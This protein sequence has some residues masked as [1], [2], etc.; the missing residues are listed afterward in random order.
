MEKL[1]KINYENQLAGEFPRDTEV[2]EI[3][4]KFQEHYMYDIL[5]ARVNNEIVELSDKISKSCD[6]TFYDRSSKLG[7]DVY[8]RSVQFILVLAVK[9]LFGQNTELFIEHSMDKGIYCQLSNAEVNTKIIQKLENE[10]K[11]I[12]SENL[13]FTKVSVSRIDAINYFQ[14]RNQYDK[15]NALKYI[16]NTYI[17]LYKLDNIYDYFYGEM[18]YSTKAINSFALNYIAENGFVLSFPN[19]PNPEVTLPY[20]HHKMIFDKF[21]DYTNWG[22]IIGV[23]NAYDLNSIVTTGHCEELI[24][25]AEAYYNS[26]L[27]LTAHEIYERKENVRLI[28]IAGPSSSGKTTTAKKLEVYLK[29]RGLHPHRISLDDYF[30]NRADTPV[31]ADG[32]LDLESLGAVDVNLFNR[33]LTKLLEGEKV[34]LPEF[35]FIKG[36]R[37]Y[38]D[39]WLQLNKDDV[40]II[41][42]LH[43]LND[44]LTLS[45]ERR[46]KFKIYLS[47]LTQLN[48]DNHNRIHTSDTRKLRR[49]IRDNKHRGYNASQTLKQ[50]SE[51]RR[52]EEKYIFPFQDD[53]DMVINSELIYE[54]AVLKTYVEPLLFSV[55]ETDEMYPEAIRLI[56]LLRVLLPMPS[57]GIPSDSV[58]REFIGNSCF[59]KD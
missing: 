7:N 43:C 50:W 27:A 59:F 56:N 38:K 31:L 19:V 28:L 45:V 46:N 35:N 26:Q 47:P 49:I 5:V 51:I 34:L 48:V 10:M 20:T 22:R 24:G 37:E 57:E 2:S 9:R 25:L 12:V 16:S 32:N 8:D 21:L 1:I 13:I 58:L 3:A 52:G 11:K 55:D 29:S 30:K 4:A 36:E 42:G 6:I 18:A 41:E 15:S 53:A 14:K 17:N 54:L 40:I 23:K 44:E 33:H 39:N